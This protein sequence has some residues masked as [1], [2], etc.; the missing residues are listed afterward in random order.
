MARERRF[1]TIR[2][3]FSVKCPEGGRRVRE[4]LMAG[5]DVEPRLLAAF[6]KPPLHRGMHTVDAVMQTLR[7]APAN[8]VQRTIFEQ[9]LDR[10]SANGPLWRARFSDGVIFYGRRNAPSTAASFPWQRAAGPTA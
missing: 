8:R 4:T 10:L 9:A 5:R 3:D 7:E 1:R 2:T 6:E